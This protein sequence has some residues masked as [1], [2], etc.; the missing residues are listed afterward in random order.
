[1]MPPGTLCY[2]QVEARDTL[3]EHIFKSINVYNGEV[4]LHTFMNLVNYF[5]K[6]LIL[7]NQLYILCLH[8][9]RIFFS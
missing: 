1:M 3:N 8:H 5:D 6:H 2:I 7:Y 4:P 9:G